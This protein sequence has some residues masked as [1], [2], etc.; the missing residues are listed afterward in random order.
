MVK[1]VNV[2]AKTAIKAS[3]QIKKS[4]IGTVK[5]KVNDFIRMHYCIPYFVLIR[6][7]TEPIGFASTIINATLETT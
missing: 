1:S 2:C 6:S 5:V 4:S 3:F 7:R